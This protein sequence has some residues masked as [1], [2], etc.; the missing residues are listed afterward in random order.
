MCDASSWVV[1]GIGGWGCEF[2]VRKIPR[3]GKSISIALALRACVRAKLRE[4]GVSSVARV[5]RA[6]LWGGVQAALRNVKVNL[7]SCKSVFYA[8]KRLAKRLSTSPR[9]GG[10]MLMEI[11]CFS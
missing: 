5:G 7:F 8:S 2:F 4:R 3:T 11:L 1:E 9:L 10:L 6:D